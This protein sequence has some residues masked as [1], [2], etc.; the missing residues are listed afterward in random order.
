L[1]R[2]E[3]LKTLSDPMI[4]LM[5]TGYVLGLQ[6]SFVQIQVPAAGLASIVSIVQ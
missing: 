4:F 2:F 1:E 5:P 6:K 3:A